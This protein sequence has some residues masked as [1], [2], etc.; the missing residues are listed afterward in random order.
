MAYPLHAR[1]FWLGTGHFL[2]LSW[3]SSLGDAR[4]DQFSLFFIIDQAW[5]T[6]NL[7]WRIL[8]A[9]GDLM[10]IS[11][12]CVKVT[13][14]CAAFFII[15]LQAWLSHFFFFITPGVSVAEFSFSLS[16]HTLGSSGSHWLQQADAVATPAAPTF[17]YT[18]CGKH[19]YSCCIP[20]ISAHIIILH[21]DK[22]AWYTICFQAL[23]SSTEKGGFP[24]TL[25]FRETKRVGYPLC[26][27]L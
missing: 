13:S 6:S 2:K 15:F 25:A 14:M 21:T 16:V 18:A 19:C 4:F 22:Q 23:L 5:T 27:P 17:Y 20:D 9:F 7:G 3:H 10:K 11:L 24:L 8:L 1:S 26:H 12:P